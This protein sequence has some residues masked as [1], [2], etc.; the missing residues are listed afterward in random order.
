MG[1]FCYNNPNAAVVELVDTHDSKSCGES[2]PG[3]SPGSGTNYSVGWAVLFGHG[4]LL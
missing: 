3:S 4:F 1:I 2:H